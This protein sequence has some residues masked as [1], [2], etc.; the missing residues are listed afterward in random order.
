MH[1]WFNFGI[2]FQRSACLMIFE[3]LS[4]LNAI[5]KNSNS[6][7]FS[8]FCFIEENRKYIGHHEFHKNINSYVWITYSS[9]DI[10]DLRWHSFK[11]IWKI[12]PWALLLPMVRFV[13]WITT[14]FPNCH[15]KCT[16]AI[17]NLWLWKYI[18]Q[19]WSIQ[20][21]MS[22]SHAMFNR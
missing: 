7:F 6:M 2:K 16:T 13:R 4:H 9:D 12:L 5:Q 15:G 20:K 19:S 11:S 1:M 17:G 22:R 10:L 3:V 21:G 14:N 18:L 8:A